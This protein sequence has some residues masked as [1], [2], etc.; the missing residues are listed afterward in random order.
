MK[1]LERVHSLLPF[2]ILHDICDMP[3]SAAQLA[4]GGKML[5]PK[6]PLSH[7]LSRGKHPHAAQG[8][9]SGLFKTQTG[10]RQPVRGP[11]GTLFPTSLSLF[12]SLSSSVSF[13]SISPSSP[14]VLCSLEFFFQSCTLVPVHIHGVSTARTEC[15]ILWSWGS[16]QP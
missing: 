4:S 11:E 1:R 5:P 8:R 6:T 14:L 2:A 7:L 15:Q 9:E 12:L 13:P 16:R 10:K 3:P